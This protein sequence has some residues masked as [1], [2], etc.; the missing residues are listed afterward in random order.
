MFECKG[1]KAKDE[2]IAHLQANV[3]KLLEMVEKSSAKVMELAEPGVNRRMQPQPQAPGGPPTPRYAVPPQYPGYEPRV[4][5]V[6][7]VDEES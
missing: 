4:E 1:C 3:A 2:E 6:F 7:E 5:T